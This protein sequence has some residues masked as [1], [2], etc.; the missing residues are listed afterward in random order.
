MNISFLSKLSNLEWEWEQE[1][2]GRW[3]T[4]YNT[5]WESGIFSFLRVNQWTGWIKK[6][7]L[8][9]HLLFQCS[10][11][12]KWSRRQIKAKQNSTLC[13]CGWIPS[14][15]SMDSINQI[16]HPRLI[17]IFSYFN[18]ECGIGNENKKLILFPPIMYFSNGFKNKS[19]KKNYSY[20]NQIP[21]L[22][23]FWSLVLIDDLIVITYY[24][25]NWETST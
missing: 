4:N 5:V 17:L 2:N 11:H 21:F 18:L 7:I 6:W 13:S 9:S 1:W 19:R 3:I 22:L 25:D 15:K 12:D 16:Y 8:H 10:K 20:K 14:E 24:I 23:K